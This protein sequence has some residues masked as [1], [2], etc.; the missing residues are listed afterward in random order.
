MQ[1]SHSTQFIAATP[2]LA[3]LD[4]RR[5]VDF[6][7]SQLGFSEIHADPGVYGIVGRG[8]VHLH[9][10]ACAD[11]RIAEA[12]GCRVQVQGIEELHT[13]CRQAGICHPKAPLHDMPWRT[14]EFGVLDP[15]GNLLTFVEL[16]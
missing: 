1:A 8:P 4:I 12:T 10:W 14:R 5:S 15:D 9:F 11:R 2:V 13:H 7:V 3:S 6:Y 16:L